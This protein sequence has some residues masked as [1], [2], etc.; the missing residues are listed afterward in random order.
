MWKELQGKTIGVFDTEANGFLENVTE[1]LCASLFDAET[2]KGFMHGDSAGWVKYFLS[3]LDEFDVLAGHN[4]IGYDLP[5]LKKLYNWEPRKDVII[6]D[7]LWLSRMYK[8]D[9]DGGHSLGSWGERL[10]NKKKEYYPV[11]DDMQPNYNPEANIKEDAGWSQAIYTENMASYCH[12]D[13]AVNVDIF[14][15]LVGLLKNFSFKSIQCEMDTAILIQRQMDHGFVFKMEEAEKLHALLVSRRIELEDTVHDTF[16]PLAKLVRVVQPRVKQDGTVSSVGLKKLGD[17]WK[18]VIPVPEYTE[19]FGS[20]RVYTSGSFS[21]IEWPEFSLGS[22]QQIAERL[23]RSGYTLTKQTEKGNYIIDDSVL[24]EA[25]DAGIKEAEPLA[26][27]FLIQKREAMLKDWISKAKWHEDQGVWRIHGY[28]NSMGANSHRMTH[29]SPN[30]AQVP[31][32]KK[33]KKG[34]PKEGEFKM[35]ADG[36]YGCDCRDLFTVRKGY[37]L[38]GCDASGLELR[39]LAHYMND[40]AYTEVLLKGDIHTANQEAAGLPTRDDAKTFILYN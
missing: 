40:A 33:Y 5:L 23:L 29:S 26:E 3:K 9:L 8:P 19:E 11:L 2:G 4:I 7:T 17:D 22:R 12:Q 30:V 16:K 36:G 31:A 39:T 32:A 13:V 14:W 15:K 28:V 24:Q 6:I 21:L 37:K 1:M 10:G 18:D 35:G 20:E 25:A 38:V 27:Y 34:H